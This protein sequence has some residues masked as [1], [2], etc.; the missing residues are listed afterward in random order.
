MAKKMIANTLQRTKAATWAVKIYNHAN[1]NIWR[2]SGTGFFVSRDGYFITADH[3]INTNPAARM[4]MLFQPGPSQEV[5]NDCFA[6]DVISRFPEHDI[7]ILK[8][9]LTINKDMPWYKGHGGFPHLNVTFSPIGE[10]TSVYSYGFPLPKITQLNIPP[11]P[12]WGQVPG[13]KE[14]FTTYRLAPRVTSAIIA[15][16]EE[17]AGPASGPAGSTGANASPASKVYVIDKA[18]N[19]GNSGGPIVLESTGEVF[20]LCQR[21]QTTPNLSGKN[22]QVLIP[23]LY[24]VVG[25]LSN[26]ESE[27]ASY[28]VW[29]APP[30]P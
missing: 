23:S 29:A 24:G 7:A 25:S 18:L 6:L 11:P 8:A 4:I 27:L 12:D 2:M 10:A 20:A 17:Y 13:W 22:A 16:T 5:Q 26:V 15:A 19:F 28:G 3:V 1:S 21:F 30:S 14:A 9:R